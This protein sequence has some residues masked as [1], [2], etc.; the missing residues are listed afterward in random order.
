MSLRLI[1][2]T[3]KDALFFFKMRNNQK[4]RKN[5]N[6]SEFINYKDHLIWFKRKIKHKN[7]YLIKLIYKKTACGYLRVKKVKKNYL[8]SIS[9]SSKYRRKKIALNALIEFEKIINNNGNLYAEV[10]NKNYAS[11]KLFYKAGYRSFKI[12]KGKVIMKKV[13]NK[14]K[15]F[16]KQIEKIR[17]KNNTNW[18]DLLRLAYDRAPNETANIMSRIYKDDAKISKLVQKLIS[19]K[20]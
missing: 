9:V 2:A 1:K 17:S 5:Y 19:K 10:L 18:M 3:A 4:D 6:F 16:I 11:K 20:N 8:I 13:K 7:Y 15:N 14:K 12:I